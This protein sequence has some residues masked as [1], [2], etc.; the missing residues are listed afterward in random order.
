MAMATP[1]SQLPADKMAAPIESDPLIDS[2]LNDM[3]KEMGKQQPQSPPQMQHMQHMPRYQQPRQLVAKQ[4]SDGLWNVVAAKQ[5][6]FY[7][8]VAAILV[9]PATISAISRF[10]PNSLQ[11]MATSYIT[12]IG[13]ALAIVAVYFAIIFVPLN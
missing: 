7:A 13:V 9:N 6:V 3:E 1:V 8:I 10:L 2:V 5:A 11:L 4:S 12:V